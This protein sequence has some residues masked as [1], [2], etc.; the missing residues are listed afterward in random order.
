MG[1][2][3]DR[4]NRLKAQAGTGDNSDNRDNSPVS[5]GNDA[6]IG[7]NVPIVTGHLPADVVRGLARL[8]AMQPPRITRP[9]VWPEIVADAQRLAADGLAS[10]ALALGWEPLQI[11]GVSPAAGGIADLEGLAVW[12]AG[13]PVVRLLLDAETCTVQDGPPHSYAIFRRRPMD[14]AVFLWDLGRWGGG[15]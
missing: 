14:G 6:P 12:L 3:L 8:S 11:W 9:N 1:K 5:A 15:G 2:W 10:Q 4:A 7:P 13:R